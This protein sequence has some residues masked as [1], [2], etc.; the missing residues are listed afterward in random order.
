MINK[1][2]QLFCTLSIWGSLSLHRPFNWAFQPLKLM[3]WLAAF[4]FYPVPVGLPTSFLSGWS[5]WLFNLPSM[6]FHGLLLTA[7]FSWLTFLPMTLNGLWGMLLFISQVRGTVLLYL[8]WPWL[9]RSDDGGPLS[10]AYNELSSIPRSL[11][12]SIN[13]MMVA[14][15]VRVG[16]DMDLS[17]RGPP[18]IQV[19]IKRNEGD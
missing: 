19:I 2:Y 12:L 8:P 5:N 7:N 6:G 4:R 16:H 10:S 1:C 15:Y 11:V 17:R 13:K 14:P 18:A 9:V 3:F